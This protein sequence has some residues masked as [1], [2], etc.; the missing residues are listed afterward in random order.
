MLRPSFCHS[1]SP[2]VLPKS[3]P[4]VLWIRPHLFIKAMRSMVQ[5]NAAQ[6]KR[7]YHWIHSVKTDKPV[8]RHPC[9]MPCFLLGFLSSMSKSLLQWKTITVTQRTWFI[10]ALCVPGGGSGSMLFFWYPFVVM[11]H[12]NQRWGKTFWAPLWLSACFGQHGWCKLE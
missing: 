12:L 11:L 7:T 4:C 5:N 9:A 10:N 2:L 1:K 3:N 6:Q 8:I